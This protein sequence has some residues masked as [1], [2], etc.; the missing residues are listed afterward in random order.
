[1]LV[2]LCYLGSISFAAILQMSDNFSCRVVRLK[3]HVSMMKSQLFC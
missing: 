3:N 1:M 2:Q